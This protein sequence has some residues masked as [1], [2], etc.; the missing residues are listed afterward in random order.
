MIYRRFGRTGLRMPVLSAGFMRCM[1]SWRDRPDEE[2]DRRSQ[3]NVAAVVRRALDLGITHLETARGYGTSERQLGR[4]LADVRREDFIVQTKVRPE[5]DPRRFTANVLDSLARLRLD[6]LDLLA[7][8]GINDFRSLWQVCRPGGCLAAARKLQRQ[9]RIGW[10]G[11][12]GHGSTEVLLAALGQGQEDGFDYINLHWYTIFQRHTPV[13]EKAQALDMGVFIISPTDKGGMLQSPPAML[14]HL[15][16]PLSPMQF[17]DLFCLLRPEIHTISIGAAVP[18]DFD[19]HVAALGSLHRTAL[20]KN[21]HGR[22]KTAMQDATGS[23]DPG[24]PWAIFPPWEETPGYINIPLILW[25]H[26]LARGWGLL[27]YAR[28]RYAKLGRDMP[29]VPGNSA[30]HVEEYD[31]ASLAAAANVETGDLERRL[32]AA[33]R[34]LAG[35]QR[36]GR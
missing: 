20:I 3:E 6:R 2:I 21:I 12:S 13:L 23:S 11:F 25:L 35:P 22:W 31:L 10:V 14:Q 5:D 1:Q 15:S 17:N 32:R 18:S 8:H 19:E 26:N 7:I 24:Q 30:A 4:V 33:H 9:G 36:G 27:E 16:R 28:Q 34:L 29:W